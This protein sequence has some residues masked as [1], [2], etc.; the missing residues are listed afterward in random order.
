MG[1]LDH[2]TEEELS[3][4]LKD[5]ENDEFPVCGA[6]NYRPDD[7]AAQTQA[8]AYIY[9]PVETL[10]LIKYCPGNIRFIDFG[11]AFF[12][13]RPTIYGPGT[14]ISVSSLLSI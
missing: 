4:M 2:L 14:P 5:P 9:V 11:E 13:D 3:N 8:P 1:G 12:V 6:V 7:I 10:A